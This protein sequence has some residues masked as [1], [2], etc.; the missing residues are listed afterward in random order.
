MGEGRVCL[1]RLPRLAPLALAA[2]LLASECR[3][4]WRVVPSLALSERYT[5]NFYQEGN[6]TKRSQ[7][8][9]EATPSVFFVKNGPRLDLTGTALWRHFAYRDE[10]LRDTLDH[11][12][13]YDVRGRGTLAEDLLYV[14]ASASARPSNISAFGPRVDDAP[15]L[16]GNQAKI[17]TWRISPYLEQ[18]YGRTA[19]LALRY[20]RDRV[21]GARGVQGFGT[22]VGDS[23][24][25]SLA[26]GTAF[27][28]LSWGLTHFRQDLDDSFSG[29]TSSEATNANLRYALTR[30][31]GLIASVGYD[32]YQF[33]G[34][35]SDTAGRN[36]SLGFDWTP[37]QRTR[38]N[39]AIGR[40]FYGQTG[41]FSLL[42]RSR[43]TAW[44]I[45]YTDGVTTAREQFLLPSTI[46]TSALLDRLFSASI[47][48]PVQ[49]QQA[50]ANYMRENGLPDSLA[51]SVNFLSNR[52]F[53]KKELQGSMAFTLPRTS[54]VLALS[55]SERIA[56]SSQQSDSVLLGTQIG[57]RNDNVRQHNASMTGRYRL[58]PRSSATA[59][60]SWDRSRSLTT[61]IVDM[62]RELRLGL[63]RQLGREVRAAVNLH[64]RFGT[65]GRLGRGSGPYHEHSI[66]ASLSVQL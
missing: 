10:A 29:E 56:L 42:H 48:D 45:A 40:H 43:R 28:N 37:S 3:A 17:K 30:R 11:S 62:R 63:T 38:M 16:A 50:V 22:S 7:F 27:G 46:D 23:I 18:R 15:Y 35:G 58:S 65:F 52:Y 19:T 14:D 55:S 24:N 60:A 13:E 61:G 25:A 49:R 8:V 36:W 54:A 1:S 64:R 39:A 5:D 59:M 44:N 6:D 34:L 20:A 12:F 66:S 4:D 32:S 57:S 21:E 31:F 53:R 47:T 51:D 2:M 33:E 9:S 41:N 26:S